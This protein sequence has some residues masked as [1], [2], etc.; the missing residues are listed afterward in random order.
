MIDKLPPPFRK[1]RTAPDG[2]RWA[3]AEEV[4]VEI[5]INGCPWTV[6]L[7]SPSDLEDLAIGLVLSEGVLAHASGIRTVS[8]TSWPEGLS[9]DLEVP[10]DVIRQDRLN[11]R[12]LAGRT[13]CGLCGVES[14][15]ALHQPGRRTGQAV[16]IEDTAVARAFD[17]LS[18]HQPLNRLTRSVHAAA[19]CSAAGEIAT[20]REDVGRHNALDKLVGARM[21]GSQENQPGFVVMSSRCSY[22]LVVK[23]A[24]LGASLLATISAPT[25]LALDLAARLGLALAA[26]GPGG[27]V[28]RFMQ[29]D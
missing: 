3:L 2:S 29:E 17:S 10:E 18:E 27:G 12:T 11:R 26:R 9:V 8:V 5:G 22:E 21:R 16:H 14:L 7:A 19:W 20:V 6:M 15:A 4:P 28:T 25:G 13:G 1:V 24:T 23:T